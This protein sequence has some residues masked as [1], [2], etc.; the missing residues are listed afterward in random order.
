[1]TTVAEALTDGSLRWR[2]VDDGEWELVDG[3]ET[4][5]RL[6]GDQVELGDRVLRLSQD[7]AHIRVTDVARES[8][9][10]TLRVSSYGVGVI[11][12]ANGRL[13]ITRERHIPPTWQITLDIGG[14][15]LLRVAKIGKS[16]RF[17]QGA[18]FDE[19]R[20]GVDLGIVAVLV[21][22]MLVRPALAP[23]EAA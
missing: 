17:R 5:G 12:A 1:M 21:A 20:Q 6:R 15:Q 2:R 9:I 18:D 11:F 23:A 14:P 10:A 8:G 16:L 19:A 13:R 22:V 7:R 3:D 4:L